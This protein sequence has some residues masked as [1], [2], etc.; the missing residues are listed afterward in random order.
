MLPPAIAQSLAKLARTTAAAED[1][2]ATGTLAA[3]RDGHD[4]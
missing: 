2:A 1:P 4:K 3:D